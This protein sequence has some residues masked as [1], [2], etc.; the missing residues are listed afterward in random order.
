[1]GYK[2]KTLEKEEL[3]DLH[4]KLRDNPEYKARFDSFTKQYRRK[5]EFFFRKETS[6]PLIKDQSQFLTE[7][8][9]E[10]IHSLNPGAREE[11]PRPATIKNEIFIHIK[12][13]MRS[14]LGDKYYYDLPKSKD[15]HRYRPLIYEHTN[16]DFNENEHDLVEI[17]DLVKSGDPTIDL[18]DNL[19]EPPKPVLPKKDEI[20]EKELAELGKKILRTALKY[21]RDKY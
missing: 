1:M 2:I 12:N 6:A 10:A 3:S 16:K 18:E 21:C 11:K 20:K 14:F 19:D 5:A 17:I 4:K 9:L 8:L 15:D 7:I 13:R